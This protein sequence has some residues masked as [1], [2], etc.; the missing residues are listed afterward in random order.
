MQAQNV[1]TQPVMV[2]HT[3]Q[4][5]VPGSIGDAP[6]TSPVWKRAGAVAAAGMV[7]GFAASLYFQTPHPSVQ[8]AESVEQMGSRGA[9]QTLIVIPAESAPVKQTADG[10]AEVEK[11]KTRNRRLEALVQVLQKRSRSGSHATGL[12]IKN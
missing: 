11:L 3:E 5:I 2:R 10:S 9:Q 8:K 1:A 12:K 6:K 7:F 4:K